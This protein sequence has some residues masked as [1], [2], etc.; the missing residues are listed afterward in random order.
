MKIVAL[1]AYTANPGDLSWHELESLGEVVVYDRTAP[2]QIITRSIAADAVLTNKVV[3]DAAVLEQL[4]KLKYIGIL[5]TGTNVVDL[6][7][8]RSK[9][10]AVTNIPSYSTESVVQA[11]FAHILNLASCFVENTSATRAGAWT[12]CEDFSFTKG[13]LT[14]LYGKRLGIVGFGTIGRRVAQVAG[15]FGL[16]VVAYGPRLTVGTVIGHVQAVTLETLFSTSDIVT[17][18]CPLNNATRGLINENTL[19]QMK[20]GAWLINTGRGPLLDEQAVAAALASRRLGGVGVDVLST[21]PPKAENP[22][23]CA[24]NCFITPHNAWA[25]FEARQRLVKIAVDNLK[26][27]IDNRPVNVVN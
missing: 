17:L 18:H 26:A 22:L 1:D 6:E 14:E 25:S 10:I 8:A 13:K 19:N 4:P 20:R 3:L 9:G 21:E 23:L 16:D 11:T 12:N 7:Y 24:P 15:A 5:A 27:F 2:G